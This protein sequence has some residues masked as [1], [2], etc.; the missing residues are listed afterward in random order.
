MTTG[1]KIRWLR[2]S[3]R[4]T[5][6]EAADRMGWRQETWWAYEHDLREPTISMLVRLAAALDADVSDFLP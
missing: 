1:D 5:Q 3:C 4:I 2:L 6:Q